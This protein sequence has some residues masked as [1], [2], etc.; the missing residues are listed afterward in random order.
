MVAYN[1]MP[2]FEMPI[3]TR[4]KTGTI[5]D[6]GRRRHAR[7]GEMLQLY[8]GMR[9]PSCRLIATAPCIGADRLR[10]Y[11]NERRI[12]VGEVDPAFPLDEVNHCGDVDEFARGDGF[13][14]FDHMASFW[15]VPEFDK[16]WIQWDPER[17]TES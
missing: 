5:R 7:P 3:V 6:Q 2:Q 17:L 11:F 10:V 9:Q 12:I 15:N 16:V 14:D 13:R 1:F 4:R 8:T